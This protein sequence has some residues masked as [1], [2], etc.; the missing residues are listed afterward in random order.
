MKEICGVQAPVP[1]RTV[2]PVTFTN[3]DM[4]AA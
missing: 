4:E 1:A 3:E 2:D